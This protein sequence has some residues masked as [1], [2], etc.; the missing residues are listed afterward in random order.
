[1]VAENLFGTE[2]PALNNLTDSATYCL[3]TNFTPAVSGTITAGRYFFPDAAGSG[4]TVGIYRVSDQASL[5]SASFPVT[6]SGWQVSN[7]LSVAVTGGVEYQVSIFIPERY[8]ATT[9]YPWPKISG[10]LTAGTDNGWLAIT[11]V[12]N[13]FATIESGNGASYFADVVFEA[14]EVGGGSIS[15][16]GL[17]VPIALGGPVLSQTLALSTGGLAV[18]IALGAPTLSQTLALSIGSLSLPIALGAPTLA[19]PPDDLAITA[20]GLAVPIALG[21][22]TL[23]GATYA[24]PDT[25]GSWESLRGIVHEARADHA[26]NLAREANPLDCPEH[27][28]PL[29]L[30]PRGRH[31]KFGGHTV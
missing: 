10:N 28:W 24:P 17:A 13:Q 14:D 4:Y 11:P 2:T 16:G 30:T 25:G 22:L 19:G 8:V 18:P 20:G 9:S 21:P 1:M 23:G 6:S 15:A 31:C 5:G 26:R 3:A 27:G 7:A 12:S 29:E